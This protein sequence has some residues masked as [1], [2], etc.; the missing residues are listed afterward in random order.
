M[1]SHQK[2]KNKVHIYSHNYIFSI[3]LVFIF[4]YLI[5]DVIWYLFSF[6][7]SFYKIL[8]VFMEK[9]ESGKK[10]LMIN[11]MSDMPK[12]DK[13][14]NWKKKKKKKKIIMF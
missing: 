2:L 8:A 9:R 4:L 14:V 3:I 13:G 6:L 7:L 12:N 5:N 11:I 10:K 1:L